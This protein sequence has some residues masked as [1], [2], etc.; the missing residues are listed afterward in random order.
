MPQDAPNLDMFC[1]FEFF[2][3]IPK[4]S[5]RVWGPKLPHVMRVT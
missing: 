2:F 1:N 4:V 5:D 3:L